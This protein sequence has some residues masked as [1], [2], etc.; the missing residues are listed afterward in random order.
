MTWTD[1]RVETLKELWASGQSGNQI[2]RK[3]GGV[4]RNAVIGK[5][6][7]LGL[8]HRTVAN[9]DRPPKKRRKSRRPA[10]T[11]YSPKHNIRSA[12]FSAGPPLAQPMDTTD[13]DPPTDKLVALFDLNDHICCWPVGHPGDEGF[14]F[15][16]RGRE[17]GSYCEA[18]AQIAYRGAPEANTLKTPAEAA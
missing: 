4:S 12:D 16:G 1:E 8:S 9:R 5:I 2:A 6:H 18:H 15:C 10:R 17:R 11:I 14:G 7:R 13:I 3:L